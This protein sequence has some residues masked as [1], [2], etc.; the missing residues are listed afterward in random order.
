METM[1]SVSLMI[2]MYEP[3][4]QSYIKNAL[5]AG[6]IKIFA[7]LGLLSQKE[8]VAKIVPTIGRMSIGRL[9]VEMP[10]ITLASIKTS[11]QMARLAHL[12]FFL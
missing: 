10:S 4:K 5:Q 2:P 11:G 6:T 3:T 8:E 9:K 12:F 7:L 1:E